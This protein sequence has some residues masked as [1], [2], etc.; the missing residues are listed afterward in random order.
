MR[1]T[2]ICLY[3][4]PAD[5]A[6]LEALRTGRKVPRMLA[7]RAGI[8]LTTANGAST[9]EIMRR[10]GISKPTVWRWQERYLDEGVPGLKRDK[11]RP[12]HVPCR[13]PSGH[14]SGEALLNHGFG[15]VACSLHYR[16]ERHSDT[17][18]KDPSRYPLK[19]FSKRQISHRHLFSQSAQPGGREAEEPCIPLDLCLRSACSA[20]LET[21]TISHEEDFARKIARFAI[22]FSECFYLTLSMGTNHEFDLRNSSMA[23]FTP[24]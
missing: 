2:D 12:S 20:E 3:L 8:F 10:T 11:I 1:R 21:A 18:C 6:E 19:R 7:W 24:R 14:C 9:V 16:A 5:R 13:K 17:G 4:G 15:C 23:C 22:L